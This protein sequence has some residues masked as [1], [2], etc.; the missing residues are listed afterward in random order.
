[1]LADLSIT[2]HAI[3]RA[4]GEEARWKD[5]IT[6]T[7]GFLGMGVFR[8][9]VRDSNIIIVII[10]FITRIRIRKRAKN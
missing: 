10:I 6:D 1:M 4:G 8:I 5:T 7:F 9:R 3:G 2:Y